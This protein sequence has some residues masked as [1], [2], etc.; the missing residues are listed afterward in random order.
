MVLIY[1]CRDTDSELKLTNEMVA[2]I[3]SLPIREIRLCKS[4]FIGA[5]M[6]NTVTHDEYLR[7]VKLFPEHVVVKLPDEVS[8]F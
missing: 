3:R 8:N 1:D 6:Y 4:R 7:V 5:E 2:I